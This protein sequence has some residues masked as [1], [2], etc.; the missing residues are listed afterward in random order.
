[1]GGG[2]KIP[3]TANV[4]G[5]GKSPKGVVA[6]LYAFPSKFEAAAPRTLEVLKTF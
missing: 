6:C 2:S 3:K 1:L 4:C 5:K